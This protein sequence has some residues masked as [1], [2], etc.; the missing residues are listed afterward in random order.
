VTDPVRLR[1]LTNGVVAG[2]VTLVIGSAVVVGA[3][4]DDLAAPTPSPSGE[5]SPTAPACTPTW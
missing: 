1:A 3:S 5:P 4:D 2:L